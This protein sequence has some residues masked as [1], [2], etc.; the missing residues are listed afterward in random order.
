MEFYDEDSYSN[1]A[2]SLTIK[3]ESAKIFNE[4]VYRTGERELRNNCYAGQLFQD[5]QS[6][7]LSH[8]FNHYFSKS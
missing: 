4:P 6:K 5:S 2:V 3:V 8:F 7:V 1:L